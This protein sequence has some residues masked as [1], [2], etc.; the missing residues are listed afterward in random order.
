MK[1][2]DIIP[3]LFNIG[4]QINY[5]SELRLT[6][7]AA[8]ISFLKYFDSSYFTKFKIISYDIE[9]SKIYDFM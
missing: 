1:Y 4:I 6:I 8:T 2:V 3:S 7:D 5:Y 9:T